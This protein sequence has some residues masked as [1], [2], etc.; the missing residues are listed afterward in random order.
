MWIDYY[1]VLSGETETLR[2]IMKEAPM[3]RFINWGLILD[4]QKSKATI[5][6]WLRYVI[7]I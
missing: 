6:H 4:K 2:K 7:L 5:V 1:K 3:K